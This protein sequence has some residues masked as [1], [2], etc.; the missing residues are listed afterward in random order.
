MRKYLHLNLN[1]QTTTTEAWEGE[2]LVKAG[3]YLIAKMLVEANVATV[4]PL[5]PDNPL[6]FSAGPFAGT[7]WSNANR[8]SVGCKSPL[9][10]GIKEANGGGTFAYAMG[11]IGLCGFTLHGQSDDWVVIANAAVFAEMDDDPIV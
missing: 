8:I 11:R 5:G 9:T 10:G 7:T 2:K 1:D 6:I 3:R 4:D